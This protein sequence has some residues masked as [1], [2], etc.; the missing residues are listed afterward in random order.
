EERSSP[1]FILD[2]ASFAVNIEFDRLEMDARQ[3]VAYAHGNGAATGEV[4]FELGAVHFGRNR[5]AE[6]FVGAETRHAGGKPVAIH[7]GACPA[8]ARSVA[9]EPSPT[10]LGCCLI[11]E[12]PC[13]LDAP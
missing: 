1:G 9:S 5:V 2:D 13:E 7:R 10:R 3:V 8:G 6:D 11:V 4:G 12:E